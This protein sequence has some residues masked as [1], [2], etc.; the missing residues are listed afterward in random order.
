M[1]NTLSDRAI[2][3]ARAWAVAQLSDSDSPQQDVRSLLCHVLDCSPTYLFTY[4]ERLLTDAQQAHF[5]CLVERRMQGEPIAYITG[6][7][8]FWSLPLAVNSSTLIPRPET[9]LLVEEALRFLQQR[10]EHLR[11]LDLGTGTGAIAL[12][13]ASERPDCHVTAVDRVPE[14]VALAIHNARQCKIDN[15]TIQQ[16]D[17]FSSLQQQQFDLIVS[18]PPYVENESPY[19]LQG[20]VQFEPRSALTSGVD[21]L[22][23]IKRIVADARAYMKPHA[24]LMIEHGWQQAAAIQQLFVLHG[25]HAIVTKKDMQQLDRLT[26]GCR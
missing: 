20:D 23:D 1:N 24:A 3:A 16:S 17:W 19:L 22:D 26:L 8:E 4:P 2:A 5:A 25:Y 9:E 7:R 11:V 21:G 14:A 13:I 18:N 15:L 12:A 6:Q 10:G